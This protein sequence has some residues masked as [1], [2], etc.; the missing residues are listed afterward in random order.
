ML[1]VDNVVVS[2]EILT[3]KFFCDISICKGAC[4]IDGDAGAPL[5]NEEIGDIYNNLGQIKTLIC[6]DSIKTL[7]EG[8]VWVFN[9]VGNWA[10]PCLKSGE[11]VYS[12]NENGCLI[13]AIE[14]ARNN[15]TIS[16]HKP[17]SCSLYPII[18]RNYPDFITLKLDR[19]DTCS[20]AFKKGLEMNVPVYIFL[21]EPLIRL[22]GVDWYNKLLSSIGS[23]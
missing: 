14:H 16:F 18:R 22:L 15:N 6:E 23:I 12:I 2:D 9:Q 3:E 13:C 21:K 1:V 17:I 8:E 20:S 7:D 5:T 4:C 19:R 11:C 10:T